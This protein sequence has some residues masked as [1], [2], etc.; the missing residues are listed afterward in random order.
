MDIDQS[1][2]V[3]LTEEY[4]GQW[5]IN[6]TRRLLH[7]ISI[8]GEGQM[9]NA[10]AVWL[11]AHLHDWGAYAQWAQKDVD[12]ALRS[13]QLADTFLI[14]RACPQALK[15]VVLECIELHHVGGDN[16]SLESI[17]LRDADVLDFLG[18]VGVLRDFSKNARDLRAAFDVAKRRRDKL[19]GLLSLDKAKEMAAV[20]VKQ[21]DELLKRFDEDSFG[22]F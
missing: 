5:G 19:P 10:E 1:E 22:C 13:R 9:Y 18:I 15:Q 2:I 11:A 3:R 12:H 4:G 20:R 6:H 17:L 21:M 16:R 7:L 14:E 8:I